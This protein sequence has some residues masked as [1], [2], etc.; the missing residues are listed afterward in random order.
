MRIV[1]EKINI[2]LEMER[3]TAIKAAEDYCKQMNSRNS[4]QDTTGYLRSSY[5]YIVK[6]DALM[7]YYGMNLVYQVNLPP[8]GH[9]NENK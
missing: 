9:G 8:V 1:C 6:G 7:V 4:Y 5:G 2:T 3:E